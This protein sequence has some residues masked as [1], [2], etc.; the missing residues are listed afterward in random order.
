MQIFTQ[1]SS[2]VR[3]GKKWKKDVGIEGVLLRAEAFSPQSS[4]YKSN[5]AHAII[6][7]TGGKW[8]T[9]ASAESSKIVGGMIY[10]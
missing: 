9:V 8:Q 7:S 4:G 6:A 3:Y 10:I 1:Y 2:V 5:A